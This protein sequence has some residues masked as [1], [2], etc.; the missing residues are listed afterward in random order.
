M[1]DFKISR[2]LIEATGGYE[3]EVLI[4][5]RSAGFETI[6]INPARARKFAD[7]M[8]KKAKTD[9]IDAE[10]LADFAAHLSA[11]QGQPISPE[12]EELRELVKQ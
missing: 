7:A 10:V 5:L 6:C 8:G 4:A 1:K 11:P 12:R 3:K 9:K 2:V